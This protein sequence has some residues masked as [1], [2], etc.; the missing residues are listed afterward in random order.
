MAGD[1]GEIRWYSPDPRGIIP[2]DRFHAPSRLLRVVR[3]G[4][5]RI[6]VDTRLRGGHSRLRRVGSW[7]GGRRHLDQ[8][9]D[10]PE[11]L[12]AARLGYAHS[13]EAWADDR[14][15]G[16]L[17]GVAL[18]GVVL[19]RVDVPSRDRR[20]ESRAGGADR[21][22]RG[23]AASACWTLSGS[24]SISGS[25]A[26]SRSPGRD[27]LA[28]ARDEPAARRQRSPELADVLRRAALDQ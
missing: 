19:R 13:V 12:R 5:Y 7:S 20:V 23:R 27:V 28:P 3:R 17:Y 11:L 18:G 9:G 25:S 14:L 10:H 24:L 16:G 21:A 15:V 26:R 2:L 4:T 1:G 6:A 8:R 22:P